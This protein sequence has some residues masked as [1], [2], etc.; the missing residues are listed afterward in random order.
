M[1]QQ[2]NL[3]DA[4]LR[5]RRELAS[6]RNLGVLALIVLLL[7]TGLSLWSQLDA[8]RKTEA[9]AAV[10]QQ[11]TAVQQKLSELNKS[12]TERKVSPALQSE[13]DSI[14]SVLAQRQEIMALLESGRLG[15]TNGFSSLLTGFARQ[16][17]T[18]L[19]LTGFT[20]SMGGDEI[21]I[22]GRVLDPARLPTY[23]QSLSGEAVFQGRRFAALEMHD[24]NPEDANSDA[25]ALTTND[26]SPAMAARLPRHSEFVLRSENA[27]LSGTAGPGAKP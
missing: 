27:V 21:E 24:V 14:R 19:W 15:N 1:S 3:Y 16:T 26:G 5:P 22:H 7:M 8:R 20:I 11:L 12:V 10:Q 4:R 13:R 17:T 6:G 25:P 18:D 9:A 2:I 23:V